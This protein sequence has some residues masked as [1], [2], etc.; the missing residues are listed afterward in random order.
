MTTNSI[1]S[2]IKEA[3]TGDLIPLFIDGKPVDSLY[4]PQNEA[5]KII[6]QIEK[7]YNFFIVTGLGSGILVLE[8]LKKFNNCYILIIENSQEDYNFV[9]Q[10]DLVNKLYKSNQIIFS[11]I[12]QLKKEY[13]GTRIVVRP[14]GTEPVIRIYVEGKNINNINIV[15]DKIEKLIKNKQ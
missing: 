6:N 10:I 11:T 2:E 8:L 5:N 13:I 9:Q 3:K 15:V 4:N 7:N 12:N 14:S 1:Y